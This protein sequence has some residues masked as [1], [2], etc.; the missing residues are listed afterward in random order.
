MDYGSHLLVPV[1]MSSGEA[2]YIVAAVACMRASHLRMLVYDLQ[3]MCSRDY[4]PTEI[5]QPP[6]K[7]II[8]NEVA[9]VMATYNK[10]A[11][12]NRHVAR[13]YHY[14]RQGT[15]LKE[16]TFSWI[17]TKYQL[18]DI[19]TKPGSSKNFSHLWNHILFQDNDD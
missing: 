1:A 8:N 19:L 3:N 12:G 17:A 13:R 9:I 11:A 5:K 14:V 6:A 2:E 7:M 10:D 15:S 4:S 18:A 16:H